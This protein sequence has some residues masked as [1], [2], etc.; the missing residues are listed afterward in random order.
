MSYDPHA[1]I[2]GQALRFSMHGPDQ[3][4]LQV[5]VHA[6]ALQQYFGAGGEPSSWLQAYRAN[7]RVIHALAQLKSQVQAG[8]LVLAPEDFGEETLRRLRAQN[9]ARSP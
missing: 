3:A 7:F 5:D 4:A 2:E 8:P 1:R 6:A 9:D